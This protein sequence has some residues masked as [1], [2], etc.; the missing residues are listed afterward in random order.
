MTTFSDVFPPLAL[1]CQSR[2]IR[3]GGG[4]TVPEAFL[5]QEEGKKALVVMFFFAF[6]ILSFLLLFT[7]S[8]YASF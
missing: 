3:G 2:D 5:E 4:S 7:G 8:E 6:S 1:F